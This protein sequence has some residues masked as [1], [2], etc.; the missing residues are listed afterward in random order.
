MA[1]IKLTYNKL[2]QIDEKNIED[3][4]RNFFIN[5]GYIDNGGKVRAVNGRVKSFEMSFKGNKDIYE[6]FADALCFIYDMQMSRYSRRFEDCNFTYTDDEFGT[7]D[8]RLYSLGKMGIQSGD[9]HY[10]LFG[11]NLVDKENLRSN[12][13]GF[14]RNIKGLER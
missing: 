3:E 6:T 8:V 14:I 13:E 9:K 1:V 7:L 2:F 5:Q 12:L 11:T 10:L 4:K